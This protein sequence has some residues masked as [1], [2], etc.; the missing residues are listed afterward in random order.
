VTH[1]FSAF[2]TKTPELFKITYFVIIYFYVI[3][4]VSLQTYPRE[5]T[6]IT[7]WGRGRGRGEG[8]G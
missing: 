8:R 6:F 7:G 2:K 5:L 3:S 1:T 4:L